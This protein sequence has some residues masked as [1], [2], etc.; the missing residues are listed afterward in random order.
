METDNMI[1]ENEDT[2]TLDDIDN[3]QKKIDKL[4]AEIAEINDIDNF[5]FID[6]INDE[7]CEN[8]TYCIV[9]GKLTSDVIQAQNVSLFTLKN[10]NEIFEIY[11]DSDTICETSSLSRGQNIYVVGHHLLNKFIADIVCSRS[12]YSIFDVFEED[13]DEKLLMMK[14]FLKLNERQ[15]K[16]I[17]QQLN[18]KKYG[19]NSGDDIVYF[20]EVSELRTKFEICRDTY[21]LQQQSDI[22]NLF[23]DFNMN[24]NR[25][26]SLSKLKYILNINTSTPD[27][28][29]PDRKRILGILNKGLYK[30]DRV[31]NEIVEAIVASKYSKDHSLNILLVGNPG[32]GKTTIIEL[33][34]QAYGIPFDIIHLNSISS[35][36]EIVG[37][38]SSYESSD[39]GNL[40]TSFFKLRT[41]QACIGLD[42]FDKMATET[43]DGNP[44]NAFLDTLSDAHTF[45]DRFLETGIDTHN[46]IYIATA[47]S[48]DN[49]P[50]YI[51]N[52]FRVISID[53][54]SDEDKLVIARDYIIPK[55][56]KSYN[57]SSDDIE[58]PD[59]TLLYMI[60]KYCYDEGARLVKD[61]VHSIIRRIVNSWDETGMKY[62][63]VVDEAMVNERLEPIADLNNPK[64]RYH[65]YKNLFSKCVQDEIEKCFTLLQDTNMD[66]HKKETLKRK[67]EYLTSIVPE[68]GGFE[69]F[70]KDAFFDCVNNTHYGLT[71]VKEKIAK[72]FYAK[73]LKKKAFSSERI[74][75]V[76]VPGI[77][78]SSICKSIAK[79]LGIP[80][81]KVSLNGIADT[82]TIKGFAPT[83][84]GSDSGN[85][86]RETSKAKT[87]RV[88]LQLDEIDKLVSYNGISA[89][90]A[91]VDLLDNSSEFTDSFLGVPIDLSNALFIATANDLSHVEPWLLDRFT[92][93]NLDGYTYTDKEQIL[94]DYLLPKLESEYSESGIKFSIS[95]EAKKTLLNDYCT[96]FGVRDLE[97]AVEKITNDILYETTDIG[98]VCIDKDN[99]IESLG[100]KPI[101]RGN[102]LK[103]NVAGFAKALAVSGDNSGMSFSIESVVIASD[104]TT[105]ITGLPKESTIDSV[106]LAKTYIRTHY[107][108]N[109]D[110]FGIHLHF[111][112][113]AVVKDGPSAG[114]AIMISLLSAV[115]NTP[116][117]GNVAYTGEIDLFGNV[118]AI[119]GTLAKIQAAEQSGC[120]KVFIPKDNY[121]QLS[122]KD[123]EQFT[124]E[125]VPVSHVSEVIDSVLPEISISDVSKKHLA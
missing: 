5:D 33:I 108:S 11:I 113:G 67:V 71:P 98:S 102:L 58:F 19:I 96:S 60:K 89:S 14:S 109:K 85:I 99:V 31:K 30:M 34:A 68:K 69:T 7:D 120:T 66:S 90:N 119:G 49:I 100:P 32:T 53:D 40:I 51:I 111:G 15:Q 101:P 48:I 97:K 56:L 76:G 110:D 86:V 16:N 103:K 93:I 62:K 75:I 6:K 10:K 94:D 83:Y 78:K 87:A 18:G 46:T 63:V 65:R 1:K 12:F 39:A 55:L 13:V 105:S 64:L 114:V 73:A 59:S 35:V 95:N 23:D 52:R 9:H 84:I 92:V 82:N 57:L 74:L 104:D 8:V 61:N 25:R 124:V 24:G 122:K 121:D 41:S 91:L 107:L 81:V 123:I 20:K 38:D 45:Y 21:T 47:N 125:I 3:V 22:E 112:E 77:G 117:N 106:K 115:F 42:E 79:G 27:K 17:K 36:L 37:S 88:L 28:E 54:Y 80:Y 72:S 116:V 70:D 50:D 44:M 2:T 29:I 4:F 26:K 43:K 118:F